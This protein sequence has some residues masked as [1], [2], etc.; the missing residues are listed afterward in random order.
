MKRKKITKDKIN[1]NKIIS[2]TLDLENENYYKKI[3][4]N[5]NSIISDLKRENDR[6]RI[7]ISSYEKKNKKYNS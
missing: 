5:Q 4:N 1:E 2:K 7:I 6:L 3:T